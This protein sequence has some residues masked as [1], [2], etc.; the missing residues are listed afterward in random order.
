MKKWRNEYKY[1]VNATQL[2]LL[3]HR[4]SALMQRDIHASSFTSDLA[5]YNVRSVYF[6]D[7]DNTLFLQNEDGPDLRQKWRIRIYNHS[8]DKIFLEKKSRRSQKCLKKS[9]AL[10]RKQCEDLLTGEALIL[11]DSDSELLRDFVFKIQTVGLHPVVI[12]E[13]DRIPFVHPI[14]NVRVTLDCNV[15]ASNRCEDFL[16]EQLPLRPIL[17]MGIHVAEIKWDEL[18]P[19]YIRQMV[20]L[21]HLQKTKFSKFYLCR[22]YT[23]EEKMYK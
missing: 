3:F 9:C 17:P 5:S 14:G 21:S 1:M 7:Y 4:A 22:K 10:T 19:D 2:S 20:I 18:L 11:R 6:D 15:R 8:S 23:A 16:K 13:Y 12:V